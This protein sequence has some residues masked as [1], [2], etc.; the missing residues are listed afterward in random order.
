[1]TMLCFIYIWMN[2]KSRTLCNLSIQ[3]VYVYSI[4]IHYVYV[5]VYVNL[6]VEVA[7]MF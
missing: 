3:R 5:E 1:M 6:N 4:Y 2:N 7:K